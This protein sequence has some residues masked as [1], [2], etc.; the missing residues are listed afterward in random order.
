MAT[1]LRSGI[2]GTLF[3]LGFLLQADVLPVSSVASDTASEEA[4]EPQQ[5]PENEKPFWENAQAFVDAYARRD[6]ESIRKLFTPEAEFYDEFGELTVGRD[7]IVA[8]FKDVFETSPE[9]MLEE[10]KLER[11]RFITADVAMEEG[12]SF[13]TD[14]S[15]GP[16]YSSR[17]VAIYVKGDDGIWRI[18]T[19]KDFPRENAGHRDELHQLS[20]LIG[21]WVSED[22]GSVV[23]TNCRLSEDGNYLLREFDIQIE[24]R[25]AMNGVQRIGWDP[26]RKQPRS[27]VFDSRGGFLEGFWSRNGD[28]WIVTS[29]GVTADGETATGTAVYTIID[30][31]M[32]TWEYRHLVVGNELREDVEPVVMVRRPPEPAAASE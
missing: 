7:A 4:A 14:F 29:S 16:R 23:R 12:V 5:I 19:L 25:R 27:W 22:E 28:Q 9:A 2:V 6:A 3:C 15:G 8:M 13:S 17:Y 21:A 20:W 18:N 32:L 11:V 26:I 30:E 1:I 24:G 31:E 10:I